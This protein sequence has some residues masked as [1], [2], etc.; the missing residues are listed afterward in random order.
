MEQWQTRK[1][2]E[3]KE[4]LKAVYW[5]IVKIFF[6]DDWYQKKKKNVKKGGCISDKTY[7]MSKT[8]GNEMYLYVNIS[9]FKKETWL[10]IVF[11]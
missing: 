4:T 1:K 2:K 3:R 7:W 5:T 10:V 9:G 11:G 8:F 6:R